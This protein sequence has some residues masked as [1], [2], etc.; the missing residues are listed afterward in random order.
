METV[1]IF[2]WLRWVEVPVWAILAGWI[3]CHQ[4]HDHEVEVSIK[5]KLGKL[6]ELDGMKNMLALVLDKLIPDR[7]DI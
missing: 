2:D 3:W 1:P 5:E 6:D 7:K 4:K